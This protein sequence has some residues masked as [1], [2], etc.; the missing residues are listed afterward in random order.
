VLNWFPA[1]EQMHLTAAMYVDVLRKWPWTELL[2]KPNATDQTRNRY[3]GNAPQGLIDEVQQEAVAAGMSPDAV[4]EHA[5]RLWLELD[6]GRA[7]H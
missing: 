1:G 7:P 5:L 4:I 3:P 2:D 6:E